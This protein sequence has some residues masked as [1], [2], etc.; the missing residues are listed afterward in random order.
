MTVVYMAERNHSYAKIE[1]RMGEILERLV[2]EAAAKQINPDE[3]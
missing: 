3:E 2:T 1:A